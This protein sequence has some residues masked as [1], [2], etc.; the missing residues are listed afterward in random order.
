MRNPE[1]VS[2]TD[3]DAG[4]EALLEL[5]SLEDHVDLAVAPALLAHEEHPRLVHLVVLFT[6]SQV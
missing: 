1:D 6:S 3:L 2:L 4:G 5:P